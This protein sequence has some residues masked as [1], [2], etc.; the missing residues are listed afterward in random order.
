MISL[1]LVITIISIHAP[2]EGSDVSF[3]F[4][5]DKFI[6]SIHAPR[7]GSDAGVRR[8]GESYR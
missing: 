4:F 2:R 1:A 7:E 5:L 3:L 6:I 8:A